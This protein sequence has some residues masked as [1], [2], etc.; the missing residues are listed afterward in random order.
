MSCLSRPLADV[1][2]DR[3]QFLI[4]KIAEFWHPDRGERTIVH[5]C[6]ERIQ[7][8]SQSRFTQ[9][10]RERADVYQIEAMTRRAAMI[11]FGALCCCLRVYD[12]VGIIHC[13]N[14]EPGGVA[15]GQGELAIQRKRE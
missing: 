12:C 13:V 14:D 3:S 4:F 6:S 9:V 7:A 15:R 1:H 11:E 2:I 10:R 8:E 5:D